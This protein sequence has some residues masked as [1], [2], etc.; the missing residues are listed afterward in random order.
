MWRICIQATY[1]TNMERMC[2]TCV[3]N[4]FEIFDE[5]VRI[6]HTLRRIRANN[7]HMRKIRSVNVKVQ[8]AFSFYTCKICAS[9]IK[10]NLPLKYALI[11]FETVV[12]D[13]NWVTIIDLHEWFT[14]I[15]NNTGHCKVWFGWGRL[16]PVVKLYNIC[17][18]IWK[19]SYKGSVYQWLNLTY[20]SV[21]KG[22]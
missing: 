14:A 21:Q 1:K 12:Y 18:Y 11:H 16:A 22:R 4:A 19:F 8:Q 7:S 10:K 6:I 15:W 9:S 5:F 2:H 20:V 17:L 3:T 13:Y